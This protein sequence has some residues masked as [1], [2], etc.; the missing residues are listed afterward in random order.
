[1]GMFSYEIR[2]GIAWVRFDSGAMNTLSRA[3]VAELGALRRELAD[4]HAKTPFDG[5]VLQGNKYGLGAGANIGEL[6]SA[7]RSDLEALIDEGH[8]VL[9]AIE[10][11]EIPWLAVVD[12]YALGGIYELALA[13][14]HRALDTRVP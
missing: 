2:D 14:R 11:G 8:E 5:V 1:M 10:E 7:Q 12:G 6:M 3:A 4:T 13:C 9:L